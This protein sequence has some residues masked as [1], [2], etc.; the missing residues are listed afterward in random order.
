MGKLVVVH[1][2]TNLLRKFVQQ[3]H[4]FKFGSQRRNANRSKKIKGGNPPFTQF[5]CSNMLYGNVSNVHNIYN[6]HKRYLS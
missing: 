6:R 4:I 2:A 1:F 5:L 3:V